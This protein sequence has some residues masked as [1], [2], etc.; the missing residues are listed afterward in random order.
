MTDK[1]AE[2]KEQKIW[3][4][5]NFREKDGRKT[6]VPIAANGDKTGTDEAHRHTWVTFDEAKKA[7]Q[8]RRYSGV[9]FVIPEGWF[10]LDI[11]HRPLDDPFVQKILERFNSYTE[12][13]VSGE[14]LHIY[15]R[16]DFSKLPTELNKDGK[17][18]LAKRYYLK[19]PHNS[20]EL[21]IGGLTNR[22]AV[23]TEDILLDEP[24]RECTNA[25]LVTLEKDMLKNKLTSEERKQAEIDDIL[26]KNTEIVIK[27]L[28]S[29]KNREKFYSLFEDGDT[30]GYGSRSE[31][32]LALCRMIAFWAG[33]D[34]DLIDSVFRKSAL[35]REKWARGDYRE[36]TIGKAIA[37]C[38]GVFHRAARQKPP[39]IREDDNSNYYVCAPALAKYVREHHKFLLVRDNGKQAILIYVYENGVYRLY[40]EKMFKGIIKDYIAEYDEEMVRMNNVNEVYQNI[41]TDRNYISQDELNAREDIIN[42]RNGLLVVTADRMELMAH[43]PAVYS[44]IQIPCKWTGKMSETPVFVDYLT[45]LTN[46]NNAVARLLLQ[47]TGVCLSNVK[48]WR[49]KKSLFL[50]GDGDTGKS[51]LK[52]LV[53]RLLGKGNFI[54]ADL[55]EIEARF[56]T[57]T[58]YGTRLAGSSDMSFMT[59]SELKTFKK[60]TGGDSL[61]AEFKGQQGFEFT[62]S[63]LLWF[64]MNR[65]PKFGGDDGKWVYNRI[66][67]VNC[68][69]VIPPEKQDKQLLDKM[70]A[71]RDGIIFLAVRALQKVIRN[72]YRFDEPETVTQAR[73]D[74]MR[75][76]N[77]VLSFFE[78]CMIKR[79]GFRI[80]DNA[81]TGKIYK[82]YVAWCRDNNGGYAKT[83]RD[84]RDDLCAYLGAAYDELTKRSGGNTYYKEYTLSDEIKEQYA[85]VYGYVNIETDNGSYRN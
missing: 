61:F 65:L 7:A 79:D 33:D 1:L 58:I 48:G 71:E 41:L 78:E 75:N 35:Y 6:K 68:P 81:T 5:W 9:G 82:V 50:V 27:N 32:D 80:G 63:G 22:F 43:T 54:G 84:F 66:M 74:Y 37:S 70:Y 14:G 34:P 46:G 36:E 73:E 42:F 40:D 38:N 56:G 72:G 10:F 30:S 85:D 59:V 57:G 76:N 44:T 17:L 67:V 29:Q 15:G 31:A 60:I 62:Y 21:Y 77:T 39:F 47:F 28:Q 25:V 49:M 2:L 24:L 3:L 23:F 18:K 83:A 11:D 8:K 53:E 26:Q 52:S 64:C 12:R 69:N 4:C 13:S 19:N 55:S 20:T 51:Q 45:T 16:C